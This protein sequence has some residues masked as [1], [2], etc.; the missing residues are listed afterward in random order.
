MEYENVFIVSF[1]DI[2]ILQLAGYISETMT[3]DDL[4]GYCRGVKV[5]RKVG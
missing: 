2:K 3:T 4:Q 1:Y 5:D